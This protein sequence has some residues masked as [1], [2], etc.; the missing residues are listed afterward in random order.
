MEPMNVPNLYGLSHYIKSS[1]R[2]PNENIDI[3]RREY[4]EHVVRF[5]KCADEVWRNPKKA[6]QILKKHNIS[7][8]Q[9]LRVTHLKNLKYSTIYKFICDNIRIND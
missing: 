5:K 8:E 3:F 6:K 4:P 2:T 7:E 9:F 1:E